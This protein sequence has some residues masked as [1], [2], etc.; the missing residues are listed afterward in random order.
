MPPP[1]PDMAVAPDMS[2]VP[3]MAVAPVSHSVTLSFSPSTTAG[4]TYKIYRGMASGGPYTAIATGLSVTSYVDKNVQ[5][6]TTYYYVATA[7]NASNQ[8]SAYSNQTTASIAT[9]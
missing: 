7:V 6:G 2:G 9:P 1:T 4:V 5:S 8:E 3:D